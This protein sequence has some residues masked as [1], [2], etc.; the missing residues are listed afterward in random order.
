MALKSI[1]PAQ[2]EEVIGLLERLSD[3]RKA[4]AAEGQT[5]SSEEIIHDPLRR[6]LADYLYGLSDDARGELIALMLIGRG[7]VEHAYERA[8]ETSSKYVNPDDQVT[9]L[10]T[11]TVR[12]SEYL[13]IG[14][15]AVSR[16]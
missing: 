9:Y 1:T 8:L 4:R 11:K 12:L 7:D 13:R 15:D 16:D 3:A 14:M 2:V 10:L 5:Q 6:E